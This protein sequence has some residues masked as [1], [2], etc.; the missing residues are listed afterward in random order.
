MLG[1]ALIHQRIG[2]VRFD[3]QGVE[4]TTLLKQYPDL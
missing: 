2:D 4:Q 1:V 3:I